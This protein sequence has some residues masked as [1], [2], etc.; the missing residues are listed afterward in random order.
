MVESISRAQSCSSPSTNQCRM[1]TGKPS[2][3]R[4][5][6]CAG[7]MGSSALRKAYLVVL[8]VGCP[9]IFSR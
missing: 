3:V 5:R 8:L 1:G 2:L 9:L 4:C 7:T 6:T